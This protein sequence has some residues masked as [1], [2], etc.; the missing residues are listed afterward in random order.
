VNLHE[1]FEKGLLKKEVPNK[2]KSRKSIQIAKH[3]LNLAKKLCKLNIFE[4]A[5]TNSYSA[6][7]HAARSLLFKDGIREKSHY[8]L[9][10]YLR[11]E[12]SNKFEKRF[13]TELNALRLERHKISYG[14]E[15]T[16]I[17]KEEAN[18]IVEVAAEF[19]VA[20]EKLK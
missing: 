12:Y 10:V 14:L 4:E 7:F 8:G 6:M 19:L 20:V 17:T 5:V 2:D 3:K 15:T 13:L 16:K 1:C 9:F 18:T 11:E